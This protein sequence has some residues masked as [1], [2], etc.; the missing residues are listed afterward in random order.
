[1]SIFTFISLSFFILQSTYPVYFHFKLEVFIYRIY[2]WFS[3]IFSISL[4]SFL[5]FI[6]YM[7]IFLY[8]IMLSCNRCFKFPSLLIPTSDLFFTLVLVDCLFSWGWPILSQICVL[9]IILNCV[10]NTVNDPIMI[11]VVLILASN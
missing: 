2:I 8:F 9:Q 6:S 1:M 4:L 7:Y 11:F 3:G 5:V 10:L